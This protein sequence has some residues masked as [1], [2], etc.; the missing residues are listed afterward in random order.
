ME[1]LCFHPDLIELHDLPSFTSVKSC[2]PKE[3]QIRRKKK[4]EDRARLLSDRRN[5][6]ALSS[7]LKAFL[8]GFI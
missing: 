6:H 5:Y 1:K 7:L 4:K 2:S 8:G 3:D